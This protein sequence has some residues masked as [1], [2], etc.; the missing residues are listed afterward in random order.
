MATYHPDRRQS[1]PVPNGP[2]PEPPG[3]IGSP[4]DQMATGTTGVVRTLRGGAGAASRLAVMG[5]TPGTEVTV[6]QNRGWGPMIVMTR[7]VR[8]AL[9]RRLAHKIEI[10]PPSSSR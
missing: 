7:D 6:L 1:D 2:G 4:L 5:F 8:L 3:A 9:G 10:A